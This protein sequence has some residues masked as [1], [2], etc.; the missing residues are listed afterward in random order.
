MDS[1]LISRN[2]EYGGP[3]SFFWHEVVVKRRK[4]EIVDLRL[5]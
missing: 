2:G 1:G 3:D 4:F 5:E